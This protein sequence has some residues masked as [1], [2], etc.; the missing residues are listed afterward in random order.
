MRNESFILPKCNLYRLDID[1]ANIDK[2]VISNTFPYIR[3]FSKY[4]TDCKDNGNVTSHLKFTKLAIFSN[5]NTQEMSKDLH[6]N[7]DFSIY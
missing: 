6:E 1:H 4:F 3:K 5:R 7:L 2:I